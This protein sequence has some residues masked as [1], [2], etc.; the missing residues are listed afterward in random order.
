MRRLLPI[1][2]LLSASTLAAQAL[3][4]DASVRFAPQFHTYD[5]KAP[6]NEKMSEFSVPIFVAVPVLPQLTVDVGTAFASASLERSI[7]DASGNVTKS[8]SELSGIT[9]TQVRA[10]YTF[11]QDFVVLTG[12]VNIPTGP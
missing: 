3:P 2:L 1:V 10:N 6:F 7:Y 9:D 11:G 4:F 5:V 12:G 8:K